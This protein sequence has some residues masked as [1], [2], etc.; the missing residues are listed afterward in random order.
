MR[1]FQLVRVEN[2]FNNVCLTDKIELNGKEGVRVLNRLTNEKLTG[3]KK[4]KGLTRKVLRNLLGRVEYLKKRGNDVDLCRNEEIVIKTQESTLRKG[5]EYNRDLYTKEE[6][7]EKGLLDY[8]LLAKE[9]SNLISTSYNVVDLD[10]NK[11]CYSFH[12]LQVR[13]GALPVIVLSLAKFVLGSEKEKESCI[14]W[15][16]HW[17][18]CVRYKNQTATFLIVGIHHGE[19]REEHYPKI[20]AKLI[21]VFSKHRE[22]ISNTT[23]K[24]ENKLGYDLLSETGSEEDGEFAIVLNSST[25]LFFPVDDVSGKSISDLREAVVKEAKDL[26][27]FNK[28]VP[29]SWIKLLDDMKSRKEKGCLMLSAKNVRKIASRCLSKEHFQKEL[30]D[31]FSFFHA[32]GEVHYIENI[33]ALKGIVIVDPARFFHT[34]NKLVMKQE[35]NYQTEEGLPDSLKYDLSRA[36]ENA[37]FSKK[38]VERILGKDVNKLEKEFIISFLEK[39]YLMVKYNFDV[40]DEYII[41]SLLQ[42]TRQTRVILEK[43]YEIKIRFTFNNNLT[44]GVYDRL[45]RVCTS[46]ISEESDIKTKAVLGENISLFR[47]SGFKFTLKNLTH[48]IQLQLIE[49]NKPVPNLVNIMNSA[50]QL[51]SKVLVLALTFNAI[52]ELGDG[53]R[54]DFEKLKEEI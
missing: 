4:E 18:K 43:D 37:I 16:N 32:V 9:R 52:V 24:V 12:H 15:I 3:K 25:G 7:E 20:K 38:L 36:R 13:C 48:E 35:T 47:L 29:M 46:L 10:G 2:G 50:L 31:T 21:E 49:S 39:N 34:I 17:I 28:N 53:I 19:V 51:V 44:F 30:D 22:I 26:E 14:D 6:F 11:D 8:Y 45:V 42:G 41:P 54:V 27:C 5:V 23:D 33:K 1:G 40:K